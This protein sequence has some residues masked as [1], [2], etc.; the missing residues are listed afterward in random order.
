M[1]TA[2]GTIAPAKVMVFGAG[3]AGLTF[4]ATRNIIIAG[5]ATIVGAAAMVV[6][7]VVNITFFD[8]KIT[9]FGV[10]I[11]FLASKSRL[12]TNNNTTGIFSNSPLFKV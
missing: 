4:L 2:A 3:V 1:M 12:I 9:F 6:I 10:K 7:V 11:A 5:G 8:V